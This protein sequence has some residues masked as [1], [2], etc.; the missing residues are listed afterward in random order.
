[1]VE[2][3]VR[4]ILSGLLV[5]IA[6]AL[7]TPAFTPAVQV[8]GFEC[9]L[10]VFAY[11]LDKRNLRVP[12]VSG[13]I[14]SLDAILIA[15]ILA[16]IKNAPALEIYG[17]LA[18]IPLTIAN[19]RHQA[20]PLLMAPIA[21][22]G[23]L[24]AKMSTTQWAA[25]ST[26]IFGVALAFL[27]VGC[28][29]KPLQPSV[30]EE[31]EEDEFSKTLVQTAEQI[32]METQLGEMKDSYRQLREAY[33]ELDRRSRRDRVAAQLSD[34][35]NGA[36]SSFY[37]RLCERISEVSGAQSAV[38]YTVSNMSDHF[39]V[40]GGAGELNQMQLTES[41][42][43]V[44]RQT[45]ATIREQADKLSRT[46]EP[47]RP[48]TNV[49]LQ[50]EGRVVAVITLGA[51]S[52]DS[53]FEAAETIQPCVSIIAN[54]IVEEQKREQLE[55]KLVETEVLYA[56]V[57]N[58]DG[59]KSNSEIA[60]RV[61]RDLQSNLQ[62]EHL[63]IYQVEADGA[64]QIAREGRNLD[65]MDEMNFEMGV[66]FE[67]WTSSGSEE[68]VLLDARVGDM[69]NSEVL[70]RTRIRSC[71]LIPIGPKESRTGFIVAASDRIAGLDSHI[72]HTLRAAA[73]ELTRLFD[74]HS[75]GEES[76]GLLAPQQFA[77]AVGRT[78]GILVTLMPAQM[79]ELEARFGKPAIKYAMRSLGLKIRPMVPKGS[80][81]CRHPDGIFLV[82]M[83]GYDRAAAAAWADDVTLSNLGENLRTQ[84]GVTRIPIQ[85][86]AKVAAI[87]AQTAGQGLE[88]TASGG[89]AQSVPFEP[90]F[91]QIS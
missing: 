22:G 56:V 8:A 35:R 13:L 71:A 10:A 65:L 41:M 87:D 30:K 37:F 43:I 2:L 67:G 76:D 7:G 45:V 1:M 53:V 89:K 51:H 62:V 39:V 15:V 73:S 29:M 16:N 83:P 80:L 82:Y 4:L 20:N 17:L 26:T 21:A 64:S 59:A 38:I 70:I 6:G 47:D 23:I 63:S 19:S 90:I 77:V 14:A 28:M 74:K 68:I 42:P 72:L 31:G 36:S 54:M 57:A 79:K 78:Q 75:G 66:G 5:F 88:N 69:V 3:S 32:L 12:A 58:A 52:K 11:L 46:F 40:R 61:A 27:L 9:S 91:A 81:I 85:L 24:I 34:A 33:R 25:P 50:H 60:E 18:L 84:D 86:R 49:V 44:A 55:R 48:T